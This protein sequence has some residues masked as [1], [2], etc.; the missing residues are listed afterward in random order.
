MIT[1]DVVLS[2]LL[3]SYL[4]ILRKGGAIPQCGEPDVV[5]FGS[6][7][8][9]PKFRE[10]DKLAPSSRRRIWHPVGFM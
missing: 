7:A 5:E 1:I 3:L 9:A 10:V 8:R 4:R 2:A 6:F